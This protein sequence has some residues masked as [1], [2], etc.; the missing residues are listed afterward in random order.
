MTS[1]VSSTS[2]RYR[3]Y[4]T[5]R[6]STA[7]TSNLG[8]FLL[9]VAFFLKCCYNYRYR[10]PGP[11][12]VSV[13]RIRDVY[14]GSRIL[15]F[16]HP[17]SRIQKKQQERGEKYLLSYFFCSQKFLKIES[18]FIFEMLKKRIWANFQRIIEVFTQKTFTKLSVWDPR[19]WIRKKPIPDP[20]SRS[21]GQK[22]TG[23]GSA[24]L[25]CSA[26]Y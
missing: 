11:Q 13:L 18:Y 4:R 1:C 15:I 2:G 20:G 3:S 16:T 10:I 14:P 8:I 17:G 26:L 12:V 22:G 25:G 21:R 24:T 23:S 19:S 6:S 7:T 9:K 5:V